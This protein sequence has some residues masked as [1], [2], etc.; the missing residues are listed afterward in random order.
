MRVACLLLVA[1]VV[2]SACPAT[3]G[4]ALNPDVTDPKG[5]ADQD[6]S[7]I[8]GAWVQQDA[9][10]LGFYVHMTQLAVDAPDLPPSNPADYADQSSALARG[11][12]EKIEWHLQFKAN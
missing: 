6:Y 3:A 5:D 9:Q 10:A 2:A 8:Q 4:T 1:A 12:S 11:V 7:D